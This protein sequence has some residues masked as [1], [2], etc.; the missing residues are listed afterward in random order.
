MRRSIE[1]VVGC[2]IT[3]DDRSHHAVV[4]KIQCA[5]N[6]TWKAGFLVL[7]VP[8]FCYD[9]AHTVGLCYSD[10]MQE[11]DRRC[12]PYCAWTNSMLKRGVFGRF[13]D[14]SYFQQ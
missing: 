10:E 3:E 1:E 13:A 5:R 12:D 14:T 6:C 8:I 11:E 2:Q 4:R 7:Q 9:V